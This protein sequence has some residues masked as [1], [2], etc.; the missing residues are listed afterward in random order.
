VFAEA[1]AI[2]RERQPPDSRQ[3]APE[4]PLGGHNGLAADQPGHWR[5][6]GPLLLLVGSPMDSTG[7]AGLAGVLAAVTAW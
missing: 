6:T 7:F 3:R 1:K 2:G 4:R 5:G